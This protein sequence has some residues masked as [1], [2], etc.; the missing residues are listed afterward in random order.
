METAVFSRADILALLLFFACWLGYDAALRLLA[1][2]P[3][4]LNADMMVVRDAW[5]RAMTTREVRIV[6]SQLMG[7]SIN[8]ASFF[9]SANLLLIAA[10]AGVLFGGEAA[11]RG[12]AEVSRDEVPLGLIEAKLGLVTLCLARGLL[13]FIWSI[14]QLNYS[15]AVIGGAPDDGEERA[16]YAR[17]ASDLLNPA[18]ASFSQ[19]VRGY[20]FA[21]AAGAWMI[22]PWGLAVGTAGVTGLLVWRQSRSAAARA[23]R[24]LRGEIEGDHD[25]SGSGNAV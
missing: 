13:D 5:M 9:A 23:I 21:L 2:G 24:R 18:L 1:R 15:L 3:G 20:Y 6:D 8:S 17:A 22:G 25:P 16:R 7:H 19:G 11:L 14:R 4:T 10:V 12:V